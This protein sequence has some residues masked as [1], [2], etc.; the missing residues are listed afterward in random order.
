MNELTTEERLLMWDA[1]FAGYFNTPATPFVAETVYNMTGD[2]I[3]AVLRHYSTVMGGVLTTE[4][5]KY[6]EVIAEKTIKLTAY[7][8]AKTA[9]DVKIGVEIKEVPVEEGLIPEEPLIP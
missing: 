3:R 5:S 9:I 6:E 2:A 8:D 4:I 7:N 1:L